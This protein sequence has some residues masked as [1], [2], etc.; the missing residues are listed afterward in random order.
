MARWIG[1][2]VLLFKFI[3][4]FPFRFIYKFCFS[5]DK[6]SLQSDLHTLDRPTLSSWSQLILRSPLF[7]AIIG[8]RR[9]EVNI[10]G[11]QEH[12][13]IHKSP[14]NRYVD[15]IARIETSIRIDMSVA[16]YL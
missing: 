4:V 16:P 5:L 6:A 11:H 3:K 9:K 7:S 1:I 12:F 14:S 8:T 2:K 13:E 15:C 10:K